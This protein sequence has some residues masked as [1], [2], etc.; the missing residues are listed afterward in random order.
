[1]NTTTQLQTIAHN[2]RHTLLKRQTVIWRA[3]NDGKLADDNAIVANDNRMLLFRTV[4]ES[5][6]NFI[7][8]PTVSPGERPAGIITFAVDKF[9]DGILTMPHGWIGLTIHNRPTDSRCLFATPLI[10]DVDEYLEF[11][12]SLRHCYDSIE[13]MQCRLE[14]M[15]GLCRLFVRPCYEQNNTLEYAY[16]R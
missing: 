6:R 5:Q 8:E 7:S 13:A 10:G 4:V 15:P 16:F 2:E 11:R 14:S 1:M 9:G 12:E 3:V